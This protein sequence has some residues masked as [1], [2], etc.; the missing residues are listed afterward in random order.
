MCKGMS[1]IITVVIIIITIIVCHT[2]FAHKVCAIKEST[3]ILIF[4]IKSYIESSCLVL[5]VLET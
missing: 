1:H 2:H 5:T 4:N 3:A